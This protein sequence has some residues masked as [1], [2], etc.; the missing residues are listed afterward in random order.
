MQQRT[1]DAYFNATE[2]IRSYNEMSARLAE[3]DGV[4]KATEEVLELHKD[5][6]DVH[7]IVVRKG[8]EA[9]QPCPK[10][11]QSVEFTCP[12]MGVC[13]S[14]KVEQEDC[15]PLPK[16]PQMGVFKKSLDKF[17]KSQQTEAFIASIARNEGLAV[18]DVVKTSRARADR[19]GGTW[20]HPMLFIDLC[21]WLDSD[22]K[23]KAL[24]FVQDQMLRFRD[25]AGE[26]YKVLC[27]AVAQ[28]TPR[29][30]RRK[31]MKLVGKAI[32]YVMWNTH[33]ESERNSH[34]TEE[35]MRRLQELERRLASLI[36][37][38]FITS[39]DDLT[40]YLRKLW[41]KAWEQELKRL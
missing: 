36:E 10:Y 28:I 32:N 41:R 11:H 35:D 33:N 39:P 27:K 34:A 8:G 4:L 2:L 1:D 40:R 23:Y 25:E 31:V 20:V 3:A 13:K 6:S 7:Q 21:M 24:K 12:Q 15:Q 19:G 22:F 9:E 17:M 16:Y 37:D 29:P 14:D 5:G 30:K 38:G 26:A 18:E